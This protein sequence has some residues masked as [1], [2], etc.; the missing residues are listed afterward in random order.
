[1]EYINIWDYFDNNYPF[2]IF[3]GGRGTGKTYSALKHAVID[4][5]DHFI[6]MRRTQDELELLGDNQNGEGA[7]PFNPINTDHN[8]NFG[9]RPITK[10]RLGIYRRVY[11]DE[12]FKYEGAP[13]G[14]GVALSTL[15]GIR[16]I[17][18]SDVTDVYYDEFIPELHVRKMKAEGT[19]F[20]NAVETINR[21]RELKGANPCRFWLLAN[22]N[23]IYNPIMIELGIVN[24]VE[25]MI[26]RGIPDKYFKDKGLAIH[27]LEA[28]EAFIE[29][30]KQTALYRLTA[31]TQFADMALGNRFSYNDFSLI[32]YKRLTGYQPI[33]SLGD[34]Y[35]YKK[36]GSKEIY[37]SY[38]PT[39]CPNFNPDHEQDV[40]RF[41]GKYGLKLV[42]LFT[43]GRLTF[44]SYDLKQ[45]VLDIILN[46]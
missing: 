14:Y 26:N 31:G 12:E 46:R 25:K 21:N 18:F 38:A 2:Q 16:G 41:M 10:K 27:L 3:I 8:T 20:L 30:K 1:M 22:S 9:F 40:R 43:A 15:S 32:S 39:K 6:Y 28:T 24:E 35:I 7:N 42:P 19:A 37:V 17:D 34:A 33:C 29:A 13:I 5:K 23:N 44:E 36:K 11:N 4:S 45:K